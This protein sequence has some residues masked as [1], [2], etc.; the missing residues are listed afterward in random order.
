MI[1]WPLNKFM[2]GAAMAACCRGTVASMPLTHIATVAVPTIHRLEHDNSFMGMLH[3][4]KIGNGVR[5]ASRS[6]N[7]PKSYCL[8]AIAD[9]AS[10]MQDSDN[11]L[12]TRIGPV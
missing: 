6:E 4:T 8:R 12:L 11:R 3:K 9:A 5:G 1:G 7:S 2:I 10:P